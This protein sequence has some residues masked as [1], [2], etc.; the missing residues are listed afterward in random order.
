MEGQRRN[1]SLVILIGF[2]LIAIAGL[3]GFWSKSWLPE[4]ILTQEIKMLTG[5]EMT[6]ERQAIEK[7][8]DVFEASLTTLITITKEAPRFIFS[9]GSKL[10]APPTVED[11]DKNDSNVFSVVP[12]TQ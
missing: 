1:V 11:D 5:S 3:I 2:G 7:Q 12:K 10:L 6:T 9:F 8:L 4:E